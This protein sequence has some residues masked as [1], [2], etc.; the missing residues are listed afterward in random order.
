MK[1]GILIL[2]KEKGP[3]SRDLVNIVSKKFNIK[4]V[5]HT[6]TLDPLATGVLVVCVGKA[7]KLVEMLT[8]IDKEYIAT[9]KLGYETDTLDVTG[10]TT[11]ESEFNVNKAQIEATLLSFVGKSLQEVPLYS[12]VKVDGKK[13]YEYARN[14]EEVIA[15]KK[16]IEIYEIDLIEFNDDE[17][18]FKVI[19]SKGTYIRSLIRD[20][21]YKL[22]T[23]A[24]MKDLVRTKQGYFDIIDSNTIEEVQNDKYNLIP[25]EEILRG[26]E[27]IKAS[28]ELLFKIKNGQIIDKTFKYQYAVYVNNQEKVI[29]IYQE[30]DKDNT[31]AKPYKMFL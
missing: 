12:A 7:T 8:S 19:V 2:N 5:G 26:Y 20:I 17:I 30:Y 15:P 22:G 14:N 1:D 23:H 18:K 16:E 9:M 31:K 24:T 11:K 3:T 13:L 21:G 10:K 4:K 25:I 6:G 27:T 29:A 28:D